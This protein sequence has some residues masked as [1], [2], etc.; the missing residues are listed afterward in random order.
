MLKPEHE[1]LF[2]IWKK[3]RLREGR[4]EEALKIS[5]IL[6]KDDAILFYKTNYIN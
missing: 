4:I 2:K 5:E 6:D 1:F 3:N